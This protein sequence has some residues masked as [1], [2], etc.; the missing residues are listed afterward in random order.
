[1]ITKAQVTAGMLEDVKSWAATRRMRPKAVRVAVIS[2]HFDNDFTAVFDGPARNLID[3]TFHRVVAELDNSK[4][5]AQVFVNKVMASA[6]AGG[7]GKFELNSDCTLKR[8]FWATP[9]QLIRA[10]EFGLDVVLQV[11]HKC[12]K[13]IVHSFGTHV[14]PLDDMR[15][16]LLTAETI[17]HI[18]SFHEH[19]HVRQQHCMQWH[20][21]HAWHDLRVALVPVH[22]QDCTFGTTV[23]DMPLSVIVGVNG[24]GM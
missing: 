23:Y 20:Q 2:S 15:C 8:A 1:V 22:L 6:S 5:D 3:N 14:H 9:E 18:C 16:L 17:L 21:L 11:S 4:H 24:E 10:K 13:E 19:E 7:Y 12:H